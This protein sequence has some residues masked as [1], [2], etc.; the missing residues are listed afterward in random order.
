SE[1][2]KTGGVLLTIEDADHTI[3]FS[4]YRKL[5]A[6][7]KTPTTEFPVFG[8]HPMVEHIAANMFAGEKAIDVSKW[9]SEPGA[10]AAYDAYRE[11]MTQNPLINYGRPVV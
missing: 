2:A 10:P 3:D 7:T 8:T 5:N 11:A 9:Q 1:Q 6:A 4:E